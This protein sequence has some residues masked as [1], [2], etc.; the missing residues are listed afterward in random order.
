MKATSALFN[1]QMS[2]AIRDGIKTQTR[3]I[4][5]CDHPAVIGFEPNGPY[6]W[7]GVA[8]NERV[9]QQYITTWPF[10]IKARYGCVGD[11][12]WVKETFYAWGR[13]ET[14][15][16]EKKKRDE[17]HF[18]DLTISTGQSYRYSDFPPDKILS[19]KTGMVGWWRRPS[20]FM[21]R[22]ASRFLLEITAIRVERLNS[23]S[24]ADAIA[25]GCTGGHGAIPGYAYTATPVEHYRWLW[26][27]INGKNSW[28]LNPWVWVVTF[29]KIEG[30]AA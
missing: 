10:G 17:W 4:L 7:K 12:L 19:G 22:V 9:Q 26:D 2:T 15:Y 16:S 18:V 3:R 23:I 28:Q 20:I 14:R 21:P 27:S 8:K 1:T 29:K 11:Y 30:G 5:D 24:D 6:F 13:W 25:E